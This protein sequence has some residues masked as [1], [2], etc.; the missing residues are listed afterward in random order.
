MSD[1]SITASVSLSPSYSPL[2]GLK[3]LPFLSRGI[4]LSIIRGLFKQLSQWLF[5]RIRRAL[6]ESG[7]KM[8]SAC[9]PRGPDL[10]FNAISGTNSEH[11]TFTPCLATSWLGRLERVGL[12]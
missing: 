3:L 7:G 9:L 11:L 5:V 10:I 2:S 1:V 6:K 8:E 4:R 12:K